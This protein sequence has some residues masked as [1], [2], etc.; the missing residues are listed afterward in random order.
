MLSEIRSKKSLKDVLPKKTAERAPARSRKEA[1]PAV[2]KVAK[3]GRFRFSY[4]LLIVLILVAAVYVFSSLMAKATV[5]LTP[6]QTRLELSESFLA[7]KSRAGTNSVAYEVVTLPAT[8]A[9]RLVRASGSERVERKARGQVVI[10]NNFNNTSQQLVVNTR[11]ESPTGK[12]YRL[13]EAVTVPGKKA[14]GQ[15]G[16]V[17]ANI[18]ADA[19]G[20]AYNSRE[21]VTFTVPGFKGS[22]RYQGFS[23]ETKAEISGGFVGTVQVVPEETKRSVTE[24]LKAELREH[25]LAAA[26]GQIPAEFVLFDDSVFINF[27]DQTDWSSAQGADKTQVEIVLSGE[28]QGIIFDRQALSKYVIGDNVPE[29]SGLNLIIANLDDLTFILNRKEQVNLTT[30]TEISFGLSGE[31]VVVAEPDVEALIKELAGV[32]KDAANVVLEGYKEIDRAEVVFRPLWARRFPTDQ[33]DITVLNSL[34][35]ESTTTP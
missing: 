18:V 33:A 10:K 13:L 28:L 19:A 16:T 4:L 31:M 35:L 11:L 27:T 20:E 26:R 21:K 24:E 6:K 1:T 17:T 25:L 30:D 32:K 22:P 29:L 15:P 23:A 3:P 5:T 14:N 9:N 7:T 2:A 34:E 12:I 8:Q